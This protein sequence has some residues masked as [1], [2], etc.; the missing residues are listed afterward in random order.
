M[1]TTRAI[2]ALTILGLASLMI[3]NAAA[4]SDD[5][6]VVVKLIEQFYHV[7]HKGLP[8]LA[9]AGI[10]ATTTAARLRGGDAKRLAEA[11]S[12]RVAF[13]EEQEFNSRGAIAGF[14]SSMN[15]AL[16]QN[17]TLLV[18]TLTPKEEEQTYIYVRDA[19]DKFNVLVVTIERREATVVQV[20]LSPK[21]LARLMQDPNGMGKAITA[22]AT[23]DDQE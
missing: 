19:G 10:K 17:W 2:A 18:Q 5:F 16:S 6:G 21:T 9:K 12:V 23:K 20:N 8:L 4:N 7:K 15:N 1:K 14:K 22:D 3:P 13:F 11:G